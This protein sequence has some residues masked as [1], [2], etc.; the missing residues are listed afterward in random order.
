MLNVLFLTFANSS[1]SPLP[2][3][4][5]EDD[6]LYATL[7]PR[8]LQLHYLIHRDSHATRDSIARALLLY[9]DYVTIF[10]Y[11]GHA[12]RNELVTV[13]GEAQSEGVA[14]LLA[15]CR[16]LKLV[17]LNGCSTGGQVRRLLELGVPAV[18][19]TS[20]PVEDNKATIFS[21]R[22]YE[23]LAQQYTLR[24]AFDFAKGEVLMQ[25]RDLVFEETRSIGF[26]NSP[27]PAP[28]WGLFTRDDKTWALDQKLPEQTL[29][30][31]PQNYEPNVRL[32][33]ALWEALQTESRAVKAFLE[34]KEENGEEVSRSEIRMQ[35]LNNMPAPVA[36]HLRKLLVPVTEENHGEGY[37]KISLLRLQQIARTYEFTLRLITYT[38][39]AQLWEALLDPQKAPVL[40]P[41]DRG[42]LHRF[43]RLS[44]AMQEQYDY[45]DLIRRIRQLLETNQVAYFVEEL[46]RLRQLLEE[47]ETFRGAIFF[48][49]LLRGKLRDN[50]VHPF[51]ITE[52]CIRAEESLAEIFSQFGFLARY[53][54]TSVQNIDVIKFRHERTSV[55][56]HH[57]VLLRNL[58]GK[59]DRTELR[60]PNYTD[61]RSVLLRRIGKNTEGFLNLSP[62]VIDANA[63]EDNTDVSKIFFYNNYD[64]GSDAYAFCFVNKPNDRIAVT[65]SEK[66]IGILK[67]QLDAFL[68]LI[69]PSAV[70]AL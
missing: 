28:C 14:Q 69:Q 51:E 41:E 57:V 37:D 30:P 45:V 35:I 20:A 31:R 27:D 4:Q 53:V 59:L 19:A 43:L 63:F 24:E 40:S 62:F 11:S 32:E 9:R 2:T 22:L 67:T 29:V 12:G 47:D 13:G 33:A 61:N 50:N 8:A 56:L 7:S 48:L 44:V 21:K 5:T 55:F 3:L 10:H 58:L 66:R 68:R 34:G 49:E 36:E 38:L 23:A 1:E 52:L 26:A 60:L 17:V 64:P 25:A 46:P 6:G 65:D 15:Q 54:L 70:P 39:L 16:Q 18:V 42:Y